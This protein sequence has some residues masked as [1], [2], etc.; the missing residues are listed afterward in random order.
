MKTKNRTHALATLLFLSIL[1][2]CTRDEFEITAEFPDTDEYLQD[3]GL[4]KTIL[5]K[6]LKNPYS[7]ENMK[8]AH[9]NLVSKN[10]RV[11]GGME[12]A[13]THYY[14]RFRPQTDEEMA[15]LEADS[16]E[17]YDYPLD[18]EIATQGNYYIDPDV[19]AGEGKWYYTSVP[20]NYNFQGV[21][22]EIM[23]K[24]ITRT[25]GFLINWKMKP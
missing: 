23:E 1:L 22:Y 19:D 5:G 18:Y 12:I 8:M 13:T 11:S 9:D 20:L 4:S 6:K 21:E 15:G 25:K 10:G 16:L 24:K 14:V 7:V 2:S 17:L 3:Q